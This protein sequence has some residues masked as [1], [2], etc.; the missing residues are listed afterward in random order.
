MKHIKMKEKIFEKTLKEY[1]SIFNKKNKSTSDADKLD[2]LFDKLDNLK[3]FEYIK[4]KLINNIDIYEWNKLLA[5]YDS[6]LFD[7]E[8]KFK[9]FDADF[10]RELLNKY[11]DDEERIGEIINSLHFWDTKYLKDFLEE[12]I[13]INSKYSNSKYISDKTKKMIERI[14]N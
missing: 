9:K 3:Y 5:L 4:I 6:L 7:Y 2:K 1:F 11:Y 10:I 12:L 14:S 13:K 8:K